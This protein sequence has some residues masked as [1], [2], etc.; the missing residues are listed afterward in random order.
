M[1]ERINK[2]LNDLRDSGAVNMWGAA[3]YLM[4]EF[5]LDRYEARDALLA[6]MKNLS[7][8]KDQE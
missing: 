1:G 6:W 7:T 8:N 3:P 5:D 4:A 2:Y